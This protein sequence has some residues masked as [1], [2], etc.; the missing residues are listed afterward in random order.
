MQLRQAAYEASSVLQQ[1]S[2]VS[3]ANS[4]RRRFV[5]PLVT[6]N[7]ARQMKAL[8]LGSEIIDGSDQVHAPV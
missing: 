5:E 7:Q 2:V 4:H 3:E 6:S 8:M 1:S